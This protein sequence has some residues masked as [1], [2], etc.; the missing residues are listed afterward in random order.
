MPTR[1]RRRRATGALLLGI[2][3]TAGAVT[4][5]PMPT[6]AFKPY[7][8]NATAQIAYDDVVDDGMV[9]VN[10][11]EYPVR[12]EVVAALTAQPAAYNAGVIGPDG[13]PDLA[14]GQSQI[15]PEETGEWLEHIFTAAWDAQ[16]DP[17]RT[18]T[19]RQQ[20]LA[21]A[22]GFTTH[23]AGDMWAHTLINTIADGV[24]PGVGEIVNPDD[25]TAAEIALRHVIA[26]GY[27]GD[28]T[29]G[30]DGNPERSIVPGEYDAGNHVDYSDDATP[31]FSYAAPTDWIYDTLVDPS[32]PLPIGTCGDGVDDDHDDVVDDGC[33]GQAFTV[34][35]PEPNRGPLIDYFLDLQA[36]LQI[37]Q[38]QLEY[39]QVYKDCNIIDWDCYVQHHP[40]Q[41]QTVRGLKNTT[42]EVQACIGAEFG[43][44]LSPIDVAD[45][46][47]VNSIGAAYIDAWIDDIEIGL[48]HWPILGQQLSDALFDAGTYRDAQN[49]WCR[50]HDKSEDGLITYE[51]RVSCED[52]VGL[53]IVLAYTLGGLN[54]EGGPAGFIPEYLLS[55]LGAPDF[56]G[57]A[58]QFGG[59]ALVWLQ[60]V[61]SYILPDIDIFDAPLEAA[62]DMLL[63]LTS[64]ALGFDVEML[65]DFLKHPTWWMEVGSLTMDL[66]ILG[67]QTVNLFEEGD[68]EYL[69]SV[70]NLVDPLVG[71]IIEDPDGNLVES[72]RLKD[73]AE[74]TLDD[75]EVAH[76]A[77]VTSKLLLLDADQ[78]NQVIAD[79]NGDILQDD[80]AVTTYTDH[81]DRPA[82]VM[83]DSLDDAP[84]LR[85]IDSDHSWRADRLP[86]F[87]T[88]GH[89]HHGSGEGEYAGTGRFPLW[90]SC[91]AR[92]AFRSLFRDWEN[93]DWT[94]P[95]NNFPDLGDAASVDPTV[96]GSL[97]GSMAITGPQALV[98][99][100][101]WIGVGHGFDVTAV[102]TAFDAGQVGV[103]YRTY[104]FGWQAGEWTE[105]AGTAATFT[106]PTDA[107]D[108][109]WVVE[110]Q[111][112]NP[113]ETV[114]GAQIVH[115]DTTAPTVTI[116]EPS[117]AGYDTDDVAS[118]VYTAVDEGGS[119]VAA[120]SVTFD[121]ATASS[122]QVLDMFLLAT[123][124]HTVDASATDLVG[125]VGT[126]SRSFTLLATS[127]SLRNNL[128]RARTEGLITDTA[129][130]TGLVDKIDAAI[131]MHQK[132]KHGTE[133]QQ[134][135]AIVEQLS[136]Q[137]GHGV[138]TGFAERMIGWITDL[139][140]AE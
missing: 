76:N 95:G 34:G 134:L 9:T 82:N 84:W 113:C 111:V 79:N 49:F 19:E 57:D 87:T 63:E 3:L 99:G 138:D 80:V 104:P 5:F 29:P 18:A 46:A 33:P 72:S 132:G 39:D 110:W 37:T 55:M 133:E 117:A 108:T 42:V 28:A 123:G 74:W 94:V 7:T 20:I 47:I 120:Q 24:F 38:A 12:P 59:D 73:D 71:E 70:M 13:F 121:G 130:H 100:T 61:L 102:D 26:E 131:K 14:F 124:V 54:G 92:P 56:V 48:E 115:L 22:Y 127:V 68:R 65:F 85:S 36:E 88:P 125:N 31:R 53:P 64:E 119:G 17:S 2:A 50:N 10:D 96:A 118:I 78:L 66:P 90:E 67:S 52:A 136:A 91:I 114:T 112:H 25:L 21:F 27:V 103:R 140:A 16:D 30:F 101:Q 107:A 139:Q 58:F 8:H 15:H 86:A 51:D 23:A 44:A 81:T 137:A 41:V 69:D 116:T 122:G 40:I 93:G 1:P 135:G 75:F 11:V 45:D 83:I 77:V 106:L 60:D 32:N 128:E 4:L 62:K 35:D 43:C 129:V 6:S 105:V 126:A 89:G 109:R 97:T 98:D